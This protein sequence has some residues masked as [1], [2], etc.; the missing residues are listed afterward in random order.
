MQK[1]HNIPQHDEPKLRIGNRG[2]ISNDGNTH[3]AIVKVLF[4]MT[5][6]KMQELIEGLKKINGF[7]FCIKSYVT[8]K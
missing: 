8:V 1:Y 4:D 7:E 2:G 5:D 6:D 3:T